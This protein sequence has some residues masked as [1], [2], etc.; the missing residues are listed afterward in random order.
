M[1]I[2][3][4]IKEIL[5]FKG[6][7]QKKF[8]EMINET[9]VNVNRYINE[10][11]QIPNSLLPTIA[12]ELNISIDELLDGE[13]TERK[14]SL[15]PVIG[16]A[17]CG[18]TEINHLQ[19]ENKKA[20]YNGDFWKQSLYCVIANGDS[21]SPEIDDGDE[22]IIDPDVPCQ[23]GDMVYYKIDDESAIKVLAIDK[24][25]HIMQF[26]PYNSS[27]TFK[28]KTIRLDDEETIERLTYHKVV[29]VNK[30]KFNNRAARLK[31]IGR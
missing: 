14:V 10:Q 23:H 15:V 9:T 11:R 31:L 24:E 25:A 5:D 16:T 28:T 21:M 7:K 17:S 27:E 8:A 3:S 4:K 29:S 13:I 6:I 2:G 1:G 19:D 18:G 26:V 20:Y 12:K 22:V 30:L